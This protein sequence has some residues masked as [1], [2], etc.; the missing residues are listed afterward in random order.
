MVFGFLMLLAEK[1]EPQHPGPTANSCRPLPI[2][3]KRDH[4]FGDFQIIFIKSELAESVRVQQQLKEGWDYLLVLPSPGQ[5]EGDF[6]PTA[7]TPL[8]SQSMLK[9]QAAG[10]GGKKGGEGKLLRLT[11]LASPS[12]PFPSLPSR[13]WLTWGRAEAQEQLEGG[14]WDR[15]PRGRGP[16]PKEEGT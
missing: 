12:S 13:A 8:S 10:R 6:M 4:T 11:L 2:P 1:P 16:R 3:H 14:E 15:A 5:G 7:A 9:A